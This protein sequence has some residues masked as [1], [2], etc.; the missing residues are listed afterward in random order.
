MFDNRKITASMMVAAFAM[1]LMVASSAMCVDADTEQTY[2]KDLGKM[3]SYTVQFVFDGSETES[4]EWDFGDGST[5]STEWNPKH[6]Y[7]D[8]G[9]YFVK[10]TVTNPMGSSEEVYKV[11][12]MGFPTVTFVYGN[13]TEDKV[14]QQSK[15]NDPVERP[16]G[17]VRDGY[18][19]NG[20]FTDKKCT[21]EHDWNAGITEPTTLYAGWTSD[22]K[23]GGSF[24]L[25]SIILIVIGV[26]IVIGAL[27]TYAPAALIGVIVAVVG[28]LRF[29]GVF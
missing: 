28:V 6:T 10:Q 22:V 18:T 19:F 9:V 3:W 8:K 2:D 15:Y 27:F 17:P 29:V 21:Q 4:I 14:V 20:W 13:G 16:E 26:L 12:I 11:E 5:K 23:D 7:A 24:D 25:V 1:V